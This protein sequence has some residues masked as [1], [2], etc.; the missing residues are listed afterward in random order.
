MYY[1]NKETFVLSADGCMDTECGGL[2]SILAGNDEG[3]KGCCFSVAMSADGIAVLSS[4]GCAAA[5]DGTR[6]PVS[7]YSYAE[8]HQAAPQLTPVSQAIELA[9]TCQ[10]KIAITVHDQTMLRQLRMTLRY[11]DCLDD[12]II[13]GLGLVEAA[14]VASANPDLHIMVDA[15]VNAAQTTGLFGL[16]AEPKDLSERL[17]SACRQAGLFTMS[18]CTDDPHTLAE[19][20]RKGVNFIETRRPDI[21]AALLPAG[22]AE[23]HGIPLRY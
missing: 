6:L 2:E 15:L 18:R 9:R 8:L 17:V 16:R 13:I 10:G 14:R 7:D 12:T 21:T 4:D 1:T 3:A 23:P 20:I 22:E 19:L 11:A 5:P